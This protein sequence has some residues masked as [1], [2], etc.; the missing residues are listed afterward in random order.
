VLLLGMSHYW[1]QNYG[2]AR[3]WLSKALELEPGL[4]GA[5]EALGYSLLLLGELDGARREYEA[6]VARVP[7][8]PKGHYGL[9]R[10]ELEETDLDAAAERFR[11]AIEL[12]DA[13]SKSDPRALE[14]RAGEYGECHA[15]LGEVHFARGEYEAARDE[16][17]RATTIAP[18]NISAFYTL[19][20]V[21]RRLGE[22]A[23][24][25]EAAG[26]YEAARQALLARQNATPR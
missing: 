26:R 19:G 9:G 10:I 11:H 5:R 17:V 24:A 15:R 12:F 25:D 4:D 14:A 6:Y 13:L 22:D 21:Y 3:P 18:G 16:L 20:L 8:D 2:A 1:T 7:G 23:L